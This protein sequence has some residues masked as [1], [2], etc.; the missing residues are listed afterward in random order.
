[1]ECTCGSG[2][3]STWELDGY[4]IPLVKVCDACREDRLRKFR[5]DIFDRYD[6]DEPIEPE[7]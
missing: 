5:P 2:Q 7:E 4:G 3:E 1:M 6:C